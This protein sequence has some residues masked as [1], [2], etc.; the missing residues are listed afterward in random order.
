MPPIAVSI[1]V[2]NHQGPLLAGAA[3]LG[4]ARNATSFN[5]TR[6]AVGLEVAATVIVRA[7]RLAEPVD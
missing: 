2:L 4:A 7:A 6:F 3:P 5:E 1:V